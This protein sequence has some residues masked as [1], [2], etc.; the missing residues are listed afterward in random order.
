MA[1]SQR[2]DSFIFSDCHFL[3]SNFIL[4]ASHTDFHTFTNIAFHE[5]ELYFYRIHFVFHP[6]KS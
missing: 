6:H 5:Y 3:S 1:L 2:F 4:L